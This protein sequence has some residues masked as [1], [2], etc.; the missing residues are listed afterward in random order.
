MA[1]VVAASG[2]ALAVQGRDGRDTSTDHT[3]TEP[4][5]A[6]VTDWRPESWHGLTVDVPADWGW[7]TTP[8]Q[9]SS[10]NGR[11]LMCGGPG[12]TV[13]SDGSRSA[14]PV[15]GT[16]WV[17]R[18]IMLSDVCGEA[19]HSTPDAPY[20]WLGADV[21]PGTV[22][23]GDGYTQETIEE[24][25]TTLTV[26]TQDPAVRRHV[27]DSARATTGCSA[28]LD[29]AP[30][31]LGMPTE[32]LDPIHSAQVCAYQA[33]TKGY[34]LVY[35][36]T[37]DEASAQRLASV[38]KDRGMA[39]CDPDASEYVVVTFS[40]KDRMGSAE[41]TQD[42]IIDPGCQAMSFDGTS[43]SPLTGP[44]QALWSSN[45]LQAVLTAF[46]GGLG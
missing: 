7:G 41:L 31:I 20:V 25:G 24:F 36:T 3:A 19:A 40:G 27:L 38:A 34:D 5:F 46:I 18:P 16:P 44:D 10:G 14:N 1:A 45:G 17:G 43:W 2:V 26:A 11:L 23:L 9:I 15:P 29:A 37:L 42:A 30:T 6:P 13:H 4:M 39:M 8:I 28:G 22:D 33:G 21:E 35:A 32:G 12:E